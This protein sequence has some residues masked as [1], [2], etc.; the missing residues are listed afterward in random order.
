MRTCRY[1]GRDEATTRF[2]DRTTVSGIAA[3]HCCQPCGVAHSVAWRR[4]TRD[5]W[6][7]RRHFKGLERAFGI[8][9]PQYEKLYASPRC[10]CCGVRP[11]SNERRLSLDHDHVTGVCRWLLCR[12]CNLTLGTAHDNPKVLRT[13]ARYL[14]SQK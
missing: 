13:L 12:D 14:E 10:K 9:A 6:N 2:Y 5:R 8:T 7:R 11:C 1:C 3:G 4:K